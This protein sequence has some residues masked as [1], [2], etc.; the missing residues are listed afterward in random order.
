[1]SSGGVDAIYV[2][3]TEHL[4]RT[5]IKSLFSLNAKCSN[6]LFDTLEI[7]N[8]S[9]IIKFRSSINISQLFKSE[10]TKKI[11]HYTSKT[12]N[13]KYWINNIHDLNLDL[14]NL[15][16]TPKYKYTFLNSGITDSIKS[17]L[18]NWNEPLCRKQYYDIHSFSCC[19]TSLQHEPFYICRT[20]PTL[21]FIYI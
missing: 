4:F 20:T 11:L 5:M 14:Q 8:L 19:S 13:T 3:L 10:Y 12:K 16:S 6:I 1:L 2:L 18:Y 21:I 15:Q 9:E 7:P 17:L